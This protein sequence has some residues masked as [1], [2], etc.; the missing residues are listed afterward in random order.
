M[1][2]ASGFGRLFFYG[3]QAILDERHVILA[4]EI[5]AVAHKKNLVS[6]FKIM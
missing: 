2:E 5:S 1:G 3:F 4:E 6:A